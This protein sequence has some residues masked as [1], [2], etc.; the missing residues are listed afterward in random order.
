MTA[1]D[2]PF[3]STCPVPSPD[4]VDLRKLR[5]VSAKADETLHTVFSREHAASLFNPSRDG[6]ARFSPLRVDGSIVPTLYLARNPISALLE[7]A[8]HEV[9]LHPIRKISRQVDLERRG[10]R[11]VQLPRPLRLI[12]LRDNALD[13]L[14]L[15]RPELVSAAAAHYPC[16]RQ[17]S[18]RLHGARPGG[19]AVDGIMW[20]SRVCEIAKAIGK[21][22]LSLLMTGE[23][24]E[25]MIVFGDRYPSALTEYRAEEVFDNLNSAHADPVIQNIAANLDALLEP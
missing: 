13:I 19:R 10:L 22:V 7:T 12:D 21:P 1:P 5:T 23:P 6:D 2:C 20:N 8:F 16:T 9:G 14:G 11:R 18:E 4:Q 15:T 17:W 24:T 3:P 25:V